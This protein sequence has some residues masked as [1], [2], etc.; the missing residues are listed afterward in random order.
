MIIRKFFRYLSPDEAAGGTDT[1]AVDRGDDLFPEI[2]EKTD[3]VDAVKDDPK[4]KELAAELDAEKGE[5]GEKAG[6]GGKADEGDKADKD[7]KDTRIPQ[8]R[9]KEILEKERAKTAAAMAEI[10]QLKKRGELSTSSEAASVEFGK[11]E[12]E[13]ATLEDQYADLLTEGHNKEAAAVR[14]KIRASERYMAESRADLKIQAAQQAQVENSRYEKAL[15]RIE[16]AY[17]ALNPDHEDFDQKIEAR[18][19]RMS[20]ANQADGMTPVAALQDAVEA[21]LGTATTAQEK[22]TSVTPRAEKDAAAERKAEAVAKAVKAVGKTPAS[23][24]A[25]G[26]SS[27]KLG[28]GAE[29][30]AAVMKMSQKE[31][32]GLSESA[33]SKMRG[34]TLA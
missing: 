33:L 10:A 23:L 12:A 1:A 4:V 22:A 13:I 28:G 3:P 11:L 7:H 24:N 17:P 29:D 32:A 14:A 21:V 5:K 2:V 9:H 20:R 8:A 27:D 34:D 25:A 30:A 16:G 18:V 31:F 6:E 19:A 26:L 15:D